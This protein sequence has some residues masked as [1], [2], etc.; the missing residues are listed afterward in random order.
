MK[1]IG[2]HIDNKGGQIMK[3]KIIYRYENNNGDTLSTTIRLDNM[4]YKKMYEVTPEDGKL[5][6]MDGKRF[7]KSIVINPANLGKLRE[8]KDNG[9]I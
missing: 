3:K 7:Y 5:L 1:L 4:P 6:T 9:Q 8:V 2:Q